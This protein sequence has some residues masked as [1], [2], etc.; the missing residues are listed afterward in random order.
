MRLGTALEQTLRSGAPL[1]RATVAPVAAGPFLFTNRKQMTKL[2]RNPLIHP[3]VIL[4][5]DE[6]IGIIGM[7]RSVIGAML[8][9]L[10]DEPPTTGAPPSATP[11]S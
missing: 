5:V 4:T 6:A 11:T 2:H 10:P 8:Q 3:E 7:A 9:V 1:R